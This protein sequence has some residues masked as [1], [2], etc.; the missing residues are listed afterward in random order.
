MFE[1][2]AILKIIDTHFKKNRIFGDLLTAENKT[3]LAQNSLIRPIDEGQVL[4]QQ[5]HIGKTIFI[6]VKGEVK[7]TLETIDGPTSLGMRGAGELIGG[8]NR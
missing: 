4:C 2:E 3:F 7:V 6:I 1:P 8:G 5:N